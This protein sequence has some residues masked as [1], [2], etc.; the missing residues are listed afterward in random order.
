MKNLQKQTATGF[1][2]GVAKFFESAGGK[3]EAWYFDY[4]NS[5]AYGSGDYPDE[6]AAATAQTTVNAAGCEAVVRG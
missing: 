5:T 4:A 1:R 2:A 3:L 6:I